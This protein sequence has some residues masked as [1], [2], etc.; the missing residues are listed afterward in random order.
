MVGLFIAAASDIEFVEPALTTGEIESG[1]DRHDDHALHGHGQ[2]A[3]DHLA[4]RVGLSIL[5]E[6]RAF[7][8]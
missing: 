3:A 6:R 2:V 1:E 5:S 4:E 8:I 7:Y